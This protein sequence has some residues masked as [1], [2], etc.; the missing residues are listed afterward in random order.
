MEN[1][2]GNGS[3]M[4]AELKEFRCKFCNRL[5]AKVADCKK[6]EIKCPKCK[7]MNLYREDEIVIVEIDENYLNKRIQKGKVNF[8]ILNH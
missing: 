6:V 5:L 8:N 1:D 3:K 2:N 4:E 7:T